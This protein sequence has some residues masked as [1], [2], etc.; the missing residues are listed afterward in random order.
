[1]E[2]TEGGIV[3]GISYITLSGPLFN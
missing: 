3:W 1:V 2:L